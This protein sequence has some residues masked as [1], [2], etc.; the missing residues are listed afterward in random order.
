M[1]SVGVRELKVHASRVLRELRDQR[2]PIDVTYRGRV[3]ARL[4]PVDASNATQEQIARVWADLDQ[5]AAEIGDRWPAN[6]SATQ[7]VREQRRDL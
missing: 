5:L 3:I 1:R 4:V 7:A 6:V 2:Q